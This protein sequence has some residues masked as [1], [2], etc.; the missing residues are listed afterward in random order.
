MT[1]NQEIDAQPHFSI[2]LDKVGLYFL[3][4]IIRFYESTLIAFI[5][6]RDIA[7]PSIAN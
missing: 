1:D 6:I 3:Q 4:T 7:I 5:L 2:D